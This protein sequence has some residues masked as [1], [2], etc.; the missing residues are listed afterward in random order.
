MTPPTSIGNYEVLREIGRGGMG[1]VYLAKDT[2]LGR[3][4]AIKALPPEL[5]QNAERLARF[6]VEAKSLASLSH[7]NVAGIF[8]IEELEG[9]RFLVLEFVE[10]ETLADRLKRGPLPVDEALHVCAQVASGM[11]AAHESGIIHRDLKPGNVIVR[12]DGTAKVLDFGLAKELGPATTSGSGSSMSDSPTRTGVP[13]TIEGQ[14]LGTAAYLSPEQARGKPLD[15]RTDVWSFGCLL[16]ECLTGRQAFGGETPADCIG[17]ILHAQPDFSIL[18]PSTPALVQMLLRRCLQKDRRKRLQDIGDARV[19]LE[20]VIADPSSSSL[21]LA[22]V[23]LEESVRRPSTL[24]RFA[25]LLVLL[26]VA[27]GAALLGWS[28]RPGA[29]EAGTLHVSV[30]TFWESI[31]DADDMSFT[32]SPDGRTLAY[33]GFEMEHSRR[34]SSIFVRH[35]DEPMSRRLDGT[36]HA[37]SVRFSPDGRWLLYRSNPP[38]SSEVDLRRISIDGG[39]SLSVFEERRGDTYRLYQASWLSDTEIVLPDDDG[40]ALYRVPAAGGQPT[41]LVDLPAAAGSEFQGSP[42]AVPGGEWVL[43]QRLKFGSGRVE[44]SIHAVNIGSGESHEVVGDGAGPAFAG[45][46][47]ILFSRGSTLCA[48]AFDPATAELA[49]PA[50]PLITGLYTWEELPSLLHQMSDAGHLAYVSGSSIEGERRLMVMSSSGAADA[51]IETPRHYAGDL[52]VSP[53]GERIAL[54]MMDGIPQVH[55]LEIATG[56]I[57]LISPADKPSFFPRWTP[58]GKLVYTSWTSSDDASLVMVDPSVTLSETLICE[59][60]EGRSRQVSP[61]F[62]PDGRFMVFL[63]TGRDDES[64]NGIYLYDFEEGGEPAPLVTTGTEGP[65]VLSPDGTWLAYTTDASGRNQIV[66]RSFDPGS[67]VGTRVHPVSFDGGMAPFWSHDGSRLYFRESVDGDLMRV[68]VRTDP[69]LELSAPEIVLRSELVNRIGWG[70]Q[71]IHVMPGEERFVFVQRP[72]GS[73]TP[74]HINLVL[75]MLGELER[76]VPRD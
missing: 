16:Y 20:E 30:P 42:V 60:N 62:T 49:G 58:S 28:L 15:K 40:T 8:G 46:R 51:L 11:A 54:V 25:A 37:D 74:T 66:L 63:V 13:A 12:S 14:V 23:A 19:E 24:R 10:G 68:D 3:D 61:T 43:F 32:I 48:A 41:R 44:A 73:S 75:N 72:E 39:P 50:T 64:E 4:V 26:A 69:S 34:V 56:F 22:G 27:V 76:T 38:D 45:G 29:P 65:A 31:G 1:V 9:T 52:C 18:P 47:F 70:I 17:A 6:T 71:M 21:S 5:A 35:L 2:K 57:R 53:D 55:V 7:T 33:L 59:F 36:E 67:G